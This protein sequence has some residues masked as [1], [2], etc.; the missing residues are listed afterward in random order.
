VSEPARERVTAPV[1]VR[2]V[3]TGPGE[4]HEIAA[5]V[6]RLVADWPPLDADTLA[7]LDQ[8]INGRVHRA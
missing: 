1:P 3:F 7:A 6:A 4:V 5:D 2:R 8:I